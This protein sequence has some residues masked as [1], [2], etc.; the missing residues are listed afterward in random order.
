[1]GGVS[2]Q[3]LSSAKSCSDECESAPS[4]SPMKKI[5]A[6]FSPPS[7]RPQETLSGASVEGSETG[8][9][10]ASAFKGKQEVSGVSKSFSSEQLPSGREPVKT[11]KF[12]FAH[13]IFSVQDAA[14]RNSSAQRS[15]CSAVS[16]VML[17]S[18]APGAVTSTV[19]SRR[20]ILAPFSILAP[21]APPVL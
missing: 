16:S 19:S 15:A 8:E 13:F 20:I 6:A 18:G 5:S 11:W 14:R 21:V 2:A 1:M 4:S 3:K 7:S 17:S 12:D 9:P 10:S